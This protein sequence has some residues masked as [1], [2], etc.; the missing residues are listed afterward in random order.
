MKK[1]LI[2]DDHEAVGVGTKAIIEQLEN[3]DISLASTESE[4]E[5]VL[6]SSTFDL[7]LMDMHLPGKNGLEWMKE[8]KAKHPETRVIM[9]TGLDVESHFNLCVDMGADGV[10][11]KNSSSEQIRLAVQSAFQGYILMP[12]E[13]MK[14]IRVYRN[15]ANEAAETTALT[16]REQQILI[17]VVKGT[18]NLE[19]AELLFLSQRSVERDLSSIYRKLRVAS[20]VEAV[21]KALKEKL[22]PEIIIK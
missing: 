19:I 21:E 15:G 14:K 13:L 22:V 5:A 1:L 16:D 17:E 11:S 8:I 20:R 18:T 7:V 9:Y 2:V 12:L 6:R 3:I 4:I 10:I